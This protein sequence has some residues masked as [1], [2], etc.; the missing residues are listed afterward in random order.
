[1]QFVADVEP[2]EDGSSQITYGLTA[3]AS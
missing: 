1:M 3:A 2:T